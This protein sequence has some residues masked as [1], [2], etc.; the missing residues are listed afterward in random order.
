MDKH[1]K[2]SVTLVES[3]ASISF[4]HPQSN[5]LTSRLLIELTHSINNAALDKNVRVIVVRSEGEKSFCAGASFDEMLDIKDFKTG[6]EFFMHFARLLNEMRKCPKIIIARVHAKAVGGG[7]GIAAVS[8][9]TMACNEASIRLGDLALGLGPFVVG[10]AIERK[11]GKTN[12]VTMSIDA[13]WH[14]A[15]WAKQ[16]GLF[17]KVFANKHDLDEAIN[18]FAK[19]ISVCSTEAIADMKK[20]FWEGTENWDSLLEARA[21]ISGKLVLSEFT[22]KYMKNF[23]SLKSK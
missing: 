13:D 21:E 3:V 20:I 19:K 16:A 17:T 23:K 10:P 18:T 7:V 11:I 14:D 8:D 15:F 4:S 22:K 9:Y 5:C 12:F 1:G 2:V 6:K